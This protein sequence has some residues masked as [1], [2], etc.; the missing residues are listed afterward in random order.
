VRRSL[1]NEGTKRAAPG[2][3]TQTGGDQSVQ[4][5]GTEAQVGER[6]EAAAALQAFLDA[7][8]AGEWRTACSYLAASIDSQLEKLSE[9]VPNAKGID[10]PGVLKG[11]S[12]AASPSALASATRIQVISFRVEGDRAFIVYR[13]TGGEVT[14]SAM[15]REGGGWKLGSLGGLPLT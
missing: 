8:A 6:I 2:V 1:P 3:P 12:A 10:C 7:R 11:L 14:A 5:F 15:F 4:T 13:G 9:R